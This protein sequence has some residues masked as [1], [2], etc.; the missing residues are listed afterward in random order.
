M[1]FYPQIV[2]DINSD[3]IK[4]EYFPLVSHLLLANVLSVTANITKIL[5]ITPCFNVLILLLLPTHFA[6]PAFLMIILIYLG[7]IFSP[8]L[9]AG[10]TSATPFNSLANVW[11]VKECSKE[12]CSN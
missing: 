7:N 4:H 1:L 3:V 11:T 8:L 6:D 10:K 2:L 5:L 9:S 12:E